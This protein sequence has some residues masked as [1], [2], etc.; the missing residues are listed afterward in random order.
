MYLLERRRVM[1]IT[2]CVEIICGSVW[3]C[4]R[5]TK[6]C[7]WPQ[8]V[9]RARVHRFVPDSWTMGSTHTHKHTHIH[10]SPWRIASCRLRSMFLLNAHLFYFDPIDFSFVYFLFCFSLN[11]LLSLRIGYSELHSNFKYS[12]LTYF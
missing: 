9:R 4:F 5:W 10:T 2:K 7:H 1:C 12:K 3:T 11:T 8:H 6:A